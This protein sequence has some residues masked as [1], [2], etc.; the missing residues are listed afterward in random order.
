MK[1]NIEC[2]KCKHLVFQSFLKIPFCTKYSI[3]PKIVEKDGHYIP[4][5]KNCESYKPFETNQEN[6]QHED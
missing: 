5:T 6:N 2:E 1:Y 3:I 4:V